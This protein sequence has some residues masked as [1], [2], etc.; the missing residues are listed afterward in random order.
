M[1][2]KPSRTP[3]T[4]EARAELAADAA[5]LQACFEHVRAHARGEVEGLFGPGSMTWRV[6]REAPWVTSMMAMLLLE[7]AHPGVG[8]GVVQN[9]NFQSDVIG[10]AR[11]TV[12]STAAWVFG[13]LQTAITT[14][15]KIHKLH[16]RVRGTIPAEVSPRLA[17]QPYRANDTQLLFWVHATIVD[18][19]WRMYE[20]FVEPLSAAE[21]ERYHEES[22]LLAILMGVPPDEVPATWADFRAYMDRI[23]NGDTLEVGPAVRKVALNLFNTSVTRGPLD[24]AL[25][26]GLLPAHLRE[27]FGLPWGP[28]WQRAHDSLFAAVRAGRRALPEGLRYL[29]GYHQGCLRVAVARGERLPWDARLVNKLDHYVDLPWSLKPVPIPDLDEEL[30]PA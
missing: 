22:N 27:A 30:S 24:E 16:A 3:L 6:W 7:I 17:G 11:R 23:V 1:R 14:S 4:P 12:A 8:A 9:S 20:Y 26:L 15:Y 2:A 25:T 19:V 29:P 18:Y 5:R 28:G 13:D 21:L 10:R